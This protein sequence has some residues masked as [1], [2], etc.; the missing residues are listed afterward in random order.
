MK[1]VINTSGPLATNDTKRVSRDGGGIGREYGRGGK[2]RHMSPSLKVLHVY[3]MQMNCFAWL[4]VLFFET[5]IQP[6]PHWNSSFTF[7][8]L[9]EIYHSHWMNN[10]VSW[11]FFT[12]VRLFVSLDWLIVW[13]AFLLVEGRQGHL[14]QKGLLC[15]K[16]CHLMKHIK[17]PCLTCVSCPIRNETS[18]FAIFSY[19]QSSFN[20]HKRRHLIV[21]LLCFSPSRLRSQPCSRENNHQ[22]RRLKD[23]SK[24]L[25]Q[26]SFWR[27]DREEKF[28][29]L[30]P[31]SFFSSDTFF[32]FK[33]RKVE[34]RFIV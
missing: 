22:Y 15:I 5:D 25:D 33:G 28:S 17:K 31:S 19:P 1:Q 8:I 4:P 30:Y 6:A 18:S 27:D 7:V 26:G 3:E 24:S 34:G 12:F 21:L 10:H 16:W 32:L 23:H 14:Q 20:K 2:W 29:S 13:M 11:S 9:T